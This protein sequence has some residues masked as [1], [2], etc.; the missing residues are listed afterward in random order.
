MVNDDD[1]VHTVTISCWCSSDCPFR[2][3]VVKCHFRLF[4]IGRDKD[5]GVNNVPQFP[6][7]LIFW[8]Q[9][10]KA[11]ELFSKLDKKNKENH[12]TL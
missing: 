4:S 6:C 9:V 3:C 5:L 11:I 1:V 7:L 10:W 12:V 8:E 2:E